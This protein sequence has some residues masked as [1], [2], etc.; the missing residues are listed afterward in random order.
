MIQ[1]DGSTELESILDGVF[2]PT[3]REE[4]R[5]RQRYERRGSMHHPLLTMNYPGA[6]DHESAANAANP[7]KDPGRAPDAGGAEQIPAPA[8]VATAED[9][10]RHG[11]V[12]GRVINPPPPDPATRLEQDPAV[13][14]YAQGYIP[15]MGRVWSDRA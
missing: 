2:K 6:E 4:R 11:Y 12:D 8:R 10:I 5:Q 3:K 13:D 9:L 15:P 7:M 1:L 14:L